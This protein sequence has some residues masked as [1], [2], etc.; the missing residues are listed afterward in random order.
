[1]L[2]A[3]GEAPVN[4]LNDSNLT[5][6]N[7]ARTLL[8]ETSRQV[9]LKGW[10]WNSEDAVPMMADASGFIYLPPNTLRADP[11]YDYNNA[12]VVRG[13]RLYDTARHSF[14]FNPTSI[15]FADIV[16]G[17]DWDDLPQA[18]RDFI[19]LA[20]SRKFQEDVIGSDSLAAM[21]AQH[22]KAAWLALLEDEGEIAD[23]NILTDNY[24]VYRVLDR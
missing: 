13:Q 8:T 1:M 21:Q 3:I 23:F 16:Y 10:H 7:M 12:I 22:E 14:N 5:D 15:V 9:Q 24:T 17:L 4:T 19:A 18:A 11:S 6:A 2:R 20:A